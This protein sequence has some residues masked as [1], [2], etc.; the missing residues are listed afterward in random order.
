MSEW[1]RHMTIGSI[2]HPRAPDPS[3]CSPYPGS[4]IDISG[5]FPAH[6]L[7]NQGTQE[8][9]QPPPLL[10]IAPPIFQNTP[11]HPSFNSP[12]RGGDV[13]ITGGAIFS[14]LEPQPV[15]SSTVRTAVLHIASPIPHIGAHHRQPALRVRDSSPGSGPGVNSKPGGPDS[16]RD[17]GLEANSPTA[18]LPSVA[19]RSEGMNAGTPNFNAPTAE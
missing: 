2:T 8:S 1:C 5:A 6:L 13:D 3:R 16:Y 12:Y 14:W 10:H 15:T 11:P 17:R 18:L 4:G 7:G 9:F 19:L